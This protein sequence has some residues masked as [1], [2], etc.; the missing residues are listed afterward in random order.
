[1]IAPADA[2]QLIS[3][4][5]DSIL[6]TFDHGEVSVNSQIKLKY[7]KKLGVF[8]TLHLHGNL[9]GCIGFPEP[10]LPLYKAVIEAASSAAFG[11]P[12]FLPLSRIEYDDIVV[13]ISI[14][15]KP[16]LIEVTKP[17]EYPSCICV[18]KDGLIIRSSYGQ[19]LLL[20]QV[21]S[22]L[23]WNPVEFL[24]NTCMKAGLKPDFWKSNQCRIYKFQA[25][26]FKEENG[27][28]IEIKE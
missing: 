13:E 7:A 21:A 25:Q 10:V 4:A 1:M 26:I 5:R 23:D 22:E 27:K 2:R 28:V 15:T 17:E 16:E 14:L 19:G 9:R 24:A 20:P 18:G 11:D 8:V 3:L 6:A 12:R